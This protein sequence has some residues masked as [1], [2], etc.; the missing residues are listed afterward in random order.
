MKENSQNI[1]HK[2]TLATQPNLFSIVERGGEKGAETNR[3]ESGALG[4][5]L[6]F[7][8]SNGSKRV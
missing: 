3:I 1:F 6:S 5:S 2:K 7:G 8:D 4:I